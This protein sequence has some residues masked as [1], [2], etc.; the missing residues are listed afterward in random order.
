[1]F[2][3]Y[4]YD[5][6]KARNFI[7]AKAGL[8]EGK[9]LEIGTGRGHMAVVLAKKGFCLVSIDL[10]ETAQQ[11]ARAHLKAAGVSSRVKLKH[12]NAENLSFDALSFENV[13]S[14][15]FMHHTKDPVQCLQEMARVAR[16]KV[17]ISD[18]NKKGAAILEKVHKLDGHDHPRS[19]ISFEVMRSFLQRNAFKVKTYQGYCQT[20]LVA[21]RRGK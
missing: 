21:D 18:V 7:L 8:K 15:N 12:M 17:V 20:V 14:V 11:A 6:L 1:L 3:K 2:K 5:I 19:P 16:A 13:I 4:G 10:D 9:I